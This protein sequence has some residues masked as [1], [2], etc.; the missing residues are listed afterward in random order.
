[1]DF[2][3]LAKLMR[4]RRNRFAVL[5]H[6]RTLLSQVQ[7]NYW[8]PEEP[9]ASGFRLI[10]NS[11]APFSGVVQLVARQPL[12]LVIL[13]RVQAPEPIFRSEFVLSS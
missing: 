10:Y 9:L 6:R 13:V 5:R 2:A 4:W 8:P 7:L 3:G 1:M 11:E 12:E